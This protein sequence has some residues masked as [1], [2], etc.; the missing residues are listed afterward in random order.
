MKLRNLQTRRLKNTEEGFSLVELVIVLVIIGILA[1]I[2]V[3][4]YANQQREAKLAVLKAD[5][6]S[7]STR[8]S[9]W[10]NNN[11]YETVATT[12]QF[13]SSIRVNSTADN[14]ITLASSGTGENL[15]YCVLGSIA[16]S[17]STLNWN[18]NMRTKKLTEGVCVYASNPSPEV[19]S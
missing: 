4:I 14:V 3:P 2:A 1:A 10:Q 17:G 13:T 19:L 7:T 8:L 18:Y 16:I 6:S 12:A 9:Q 15:Q 5:I 11:G